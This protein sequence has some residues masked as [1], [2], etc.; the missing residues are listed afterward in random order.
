MNILTYL[1]QLFFPSFCSYCREFLSQDT[2]LCVG[3]LGRIKP[4]VTYP[5]QITKNYEVPV[6]SIGSYKE[7]LRSLIRAK[8]Y[9]HQKT[10]HELGKLLWDMTNLKHQKFDII[11]PIPLHWTRYAWRWFNQSEEIAK[12]LSQESNKPIVKLLTRT[13][14][15]RFQMGLSRQERI[16]NIQDVFSLSL[17]AQLYKNKHI[18]L[19]DDVLTTGA[20]LKAAVKVLRKQSPASISI[21]VVA[22]VI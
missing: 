17:D 4:I 19:I 5:L 13:K 7:P 8:H 20:T 12:V 21:A 18:L 1:Q 14:K 15:T 10:S 16:Q 22:R 3:C 6:F 9:R 2:I 11:V